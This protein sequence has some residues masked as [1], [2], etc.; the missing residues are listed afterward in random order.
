MLQTF[1][2][3]HNNACI[4]LI[5]FSNPSWRNCHKFEYH[6]CGNTGLRCPFKAIVDL[7]NYRIPPQ[8]VHLVEVRSS[9]QQFETVVTCLR[10]PI[11]VITIVYQPPVN[12]VGFSII[13]RFRSAQQWTIK[14]WHHGN[15]T[16]VC[17]CLLYHH[18]YTVPHQSRKTT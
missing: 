5:G 2:G 12:L 11:L 8:H 13:H 14:L 10:F 3:Y 9:W 18:G 17:V 1:S 15:A 7:S 4:F 6:E 16:H